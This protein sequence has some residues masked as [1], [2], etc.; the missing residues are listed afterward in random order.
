MGK[1]VLAIICLFFPIIIWGQ[2]SY[3]G[4]P[5]SFQLAY[6]KKALSGRPISLP[7]IRGQS[8]TMDNGFSIP[9]YVDISA[10]DASYTTTLKDGGTLRTFKIQ[11]EGAEGLYVFFEKFYLRKGARLFIF[12]E[13]RQTV[14]GAFTHQNNTPGGRFMVGAIPGQ[15]AI[16]EWYEPP[17]H[18]SEL[19]S[20]F[21]INR[22]DGIPSWQVMERSASECQTDAV[23]YEELEDQKK[24]ICRIVIVVEEGMGFCT[25][26]LIN[27]TALD[28][29]PLVLSAFHCSDGYTPIYDLW[30]F[31]FQ[32]EQK[33]CGAGIEDLSFSSILGA[34]VLAGRREN[35]F[36][37]FELSDSIPPPFKVT[38]NGWDR[39]GVPP[40]ES[41]IFHHPGGDEKMVASSSQEAV[42]FTSDITWNNFQVV[43]G[44]S[45]P[46]VTPA[47]HHYRVR[48]QQGKLIE[49]SSG[50]PLFNPQGL[51]LGQLHGG[52][53][54]CDGG[55]AYFGRFNLS[56]EGGGT[57]ESRLLDWLDPMGNQPVTLP[58]L[59]ADTVD[60]GTLSG[61][62]VFHDEGMPNV[63]VRL[64]DGEDLTFLEE[65]YS[66]ASGNFTLTRRPVG[67]YLMQFEK[68][69]RATNGVSTLD[70][71]L[72]HSHII[73]VNP[74]QS[75]QEMAAS[76]I[77]DSGSVSTL[78]RIKIQKVILGIDQTLGNYSEWLF[79]ENQMKIPNTGF[80]ITIRKGNQSISINGVKLG[81]V[82]FSAHLN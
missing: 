37:L 80:P 46:I 8:P 48:Y 30:R 57:P 75:N 32:L 43:N 71:I 20:S 35:D 10:K 63:L 61:Q 67:N 72:I 27:N 50:A 36:L 70:I 15:Q 55:T 73:G 11:L 28:Q 47:N 19:P 16:I 49:G 7:D 17:N 53:A 41:V 40:E 18:A 12:S 25:G 22:V 29:R 26:T 9:Q 6:G 23:C 68:P 5:L 60:M 39:S 51:V 42:I 59:V 24:G 31:D 34:E 33:S 21:F 76:D 58:P 45:I 78:D 81:D 77:N 38:Y 82:N 54:I 13:D 65:V 1:R 69:D 74:F 2:R 66:D 56:W 4:A 64:L 14:L 3:G 62:I 52:N 79:F 44:D